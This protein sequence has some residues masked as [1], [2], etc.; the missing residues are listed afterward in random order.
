MKIQ[1]RKNQNHQKELASLIQWP[2][3]SLHF[4]SVRG[5]FEEVVE[6]AESP[7]YFQWSFEEFQPYQQRYHP[8]KIHL[9]VGFLAEKGIRRHNQSQSDWNSNFHL[10]HSKAHSR[11]Q[12]LT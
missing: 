7:A 11:S 8:T 10:A 9:F 6:K 5:N 4:L 2:F 12:F 3:E 1:M